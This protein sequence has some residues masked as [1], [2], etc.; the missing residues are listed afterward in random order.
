MFERHLHVAETLAVRAQ[1]TVNMG[2]IRFHFD[3]NVGEIQ[4][5]KDCW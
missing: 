2:S 4:K 3:D 5:S 1:R